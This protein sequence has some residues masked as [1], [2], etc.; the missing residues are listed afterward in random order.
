MSSMYVHYEQKLQKTNKQTKNNL[1]Y[2]FFLKAYCIAF[3][4]L[5]WRSSDS[6]PFVFADEGNLFSMS[7]WG[8][9]NLIH[10]DELS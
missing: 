5:A 6:P 3:Y 7:T 2:R 10:T 8:K 4:L 9:H 1:K